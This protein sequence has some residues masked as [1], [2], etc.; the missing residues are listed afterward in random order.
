MVSTPW[1]RSWPPLR[2]RDATGQGSRIR[3]PL[4]DVA[5]AT[6]ANLGFLTEVM[7]NG[8]QRPRLGNSLFGQYGQNF[9]SSD[10]VSFMIVALTARHFRDLARTDRNRQSRCGGGRSTRGGLQP[11]KASATNTAT[12]SPDLFAAWFR[13]HTAD[14]VTAALS[15]SSV[16]WDRY[17]SFAEVVADPRVTANPL[18]ASV[19]QPRVGTYLAPGLPMS[20]DGAHTAPKPAPSLGDDTA[21]VLAELGLSPREIADLVESGS[22]AT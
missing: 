21:A 5:L 18:F 19:D 14:E 9:T 1:W 11:T 16:L 12:C 8:T 7:V 3:L 15:A 22:V 6:A 10:G 2:R 20:V 13:S 17:R 4:D